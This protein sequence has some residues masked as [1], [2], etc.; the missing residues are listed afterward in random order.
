MNIHQD[1]ADRERNDQTDDEAFDLVR[2]E[3]FGS[4]LVEAVFFLNH[5][6]LMPGEGNHD[7]RRQGGKKEHRKHLEEAAFLRKKAGES[8]VGIESQQRQI[9]DEGN[10]G[11]DDGKA[12]LIRV[13]GPP[14]QIG[15]PVIY[16]SHI[17]GNRIFCRPHADDI[18][19]QTVQPDHSNNDQNKYFQVH[20]LPPCAFCGFIHHITKMPAVT[21]Q[22]RKNIRAY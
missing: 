1:C 5:H 18:Q 20:N 4:R 19:Q 11:S 12:G 7:Q 22:I 21:L 16:I 15:L 10:R 17:I 8:G 14:F 6:G 2:P 3:G 13:I 9:D